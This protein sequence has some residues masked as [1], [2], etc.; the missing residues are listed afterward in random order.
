MEDNNGV[1]EVEN[2]NKKNNNKKTNKSN[3]IIALLV[4]IIIL[5]VSFIT[6]ILTGVINFNG[7]EK[8]A[9]NNDIKDFLDNNFSNSN[10]NKTEDEKKYVTIT[11]N[12]VRVREKATTT[13]SKVLGSVSKGEQYELID[14]N[15]N[16]SGNGC[17]KDWYKIDYKGHVGYVCGEYAT[18]DVDSI[19]TSECIDT[20]KYTYIKDDEAAKIV[21]SFY[22]VKTIE[23]KKDK[24]SIIQF[25]DWGNNY[26][27]CE[28]DY[29]KEVS[30]KDIGLN[31]LSESNYYAI[32]KNYNSYKELET[33]LNKYVTQNYINNNIFVSMPYVY[34][35]GAEYYYKEYNKKLYGATPHKGGYDLKELT[36]KNKYNIISHTSDTINVV[37]DRYYK[38]TDDAGETYESKETVYIILKKEKDSWKLESKKHICE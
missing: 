35:E 36:S 24:Q 27:F 6:L 29:N 38:L 11:G 20:E 3:I 33:Y 30:G 18:L 22:E 21:N 15:L 28:F 37:V 12:G 14:K 23:G 1:V 9:V 17:T 2:Y 8:P 34:K 4:V 32:C 16:S 13:N 25:I 26:S 19:N 10:S 7:K 5:L 31:G